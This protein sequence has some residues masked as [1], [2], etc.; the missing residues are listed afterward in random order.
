MLPAALRF[1]LL[2]HIF[3]L[4]EVGGCSQSPKTPHTAVRN[5]GV[6]EKRIFSLFPRDRFYCL[7]F[8]FLTSRC[9]CAHVGVPVLME[10]TIVTEIGWSCLFLWWPG[11]GGHLS[12][13]ERCSSCHPQLHQGRAT[14]PRPL[15]SRAV[16]AAFSRESEPYRQQMHQDSAHLAWLKPESGDASPPPTAGVQDPGGAVPMTAVAPKTRN[17]VQGRTGQTRAGL[18]RTG[19]GG[20]GQGRTRQDGAERDRTG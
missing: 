16:E 7:S 18:D 14:L 11:H 3:R 10:G 8:S 5:S 6:T 2:P 12:R 19:Q 9:V 17:P 15:E 20:A 13:L 4:E 1:F